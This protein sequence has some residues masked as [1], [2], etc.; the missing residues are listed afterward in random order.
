MNKYHCSA[1]EV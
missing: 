1:G